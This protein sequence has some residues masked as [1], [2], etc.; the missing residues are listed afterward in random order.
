MQ[1]QAFH[2]G[3]LLLSAATFADFQE[4]VL[5]RLRVGRVDDARELW[6]SVVEIVHK[7]F[8]MAPLVQP[9]G[10]PLLRQMPCTLE[11][12]QRCRDGR[13]GF[14][15]PWIGTW[16][17]RACIAEGESNP[18]SAWERLDRCDEKLDLIAAAGFSNRLTA[19]AMSP[20]CMEV[21]LERATG[22]PGFASRV[23]VLDCWRA[24]RLGH[25]AW[26]DPKPTPGRETAQTNPRARAQRT[27]CLWMEEAWDT[28]GP[29]PR[30]CRICGTP[31]TRVCRECWGCCC[32]DCAGH[33]AASR[34]CNHEWLPR[35][36]WV[37]ASGELPVAWHG[38]DPSG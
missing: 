34:C 33:P 32:Q 2:C 36:E 30:A 28:S 10:L 19:D 31:S 20:P 21:L 24:Y 23:D 15:F 6:G 35:V 1:S 4:E 22:G 17:R 9:P 14:N 8:P 26:F 25:Q 29:L 27:L 11:G 5:A 13:G 16:T 12:C 18:A 38:G 37:D 3:Q 7:P